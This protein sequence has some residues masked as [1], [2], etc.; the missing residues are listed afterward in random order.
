MQKILHILYLSDKAG[1]LVTSGAEN[2]VLS[3]LERL[4]KI[5]IQPS[6]LI[7]T[8]HSGARVIEI[9]NKLRA[10]QI[11]VNIFTRDPFRSYREK[12]FNSLKVYIQIFKHLHK[13]KFDGVHIHLDETY[14]PCLLFL[15]KLLKRKP[16][17]AFFTFHN[18]EGHSKYYTYR[19]R[20]QVLCRLYNRFS[21]ITE[22]VR[23]YV[24]SNFRIPADQIETIRYSYQNDIGKVN[25]KRSLLTTE[26][27]N[28]YKFKIVFLGRLVEQKN[29][30][31]IL[32][33]AQLEPDYFFALFGEGELRR[34]L[35]D[36]IR[37]NKLNNVKLYGALADG[38]AYIS[39]FDCLLLPSKR[40]GLGMVLLEAMS[41]GVPVVASNAG[42][43]PEVLALGEAGLLAQSD[44][45]DS[46]RK[47]LRSIAE[48]SEVR[49]AVTVNAKKQLEQFFSEQRMLDQY[50]SFYLNN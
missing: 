4:N 14:L 25:K 30:L 43:I 46:F 33:I 26:I 18:D 28:R 8:L 36:Y 7:I 41:Q 35:E 48:N 15:L 5:E 40:E 10:S 17:K 47:A 16:F 49:Q 6:L 44:D 50:R 32:K 22:H 13:E 23:Q 19:I 1:H 27:V 11:P 2:H 45:L 24:I 42:A 38:A 29:P 37:E 3:L 31:L 34:E 39:D 12:I 9:M 21:A 20:Y